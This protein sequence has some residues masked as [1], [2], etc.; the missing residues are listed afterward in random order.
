MEKNLREKLLDLQKNVKP[1][2]INEYF[3]SDFADDYAYFE[4]DKISTKVLD[5]LNTEFIDIDIDY[6]D[7]SN[8][9]NKVYDTLEK[10]LLML[11][12]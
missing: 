6:R 9:E 5:F 2:D 8:F 1:I 12:Q 4:Q 10:A 3:A 11:E 7:T